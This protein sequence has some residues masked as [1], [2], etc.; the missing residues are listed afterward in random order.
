LEAASE[1]KEH[2]LLEGC[3][4]GLRGEVVEA[5]GGWC[6]AQPA[7]E[8]RRRAD[9]LHERSV[10]LRRHDHDPRPWL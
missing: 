9:L 7:A 2:Q 4:R 10:D 5:A 3:R 8:H 6:R 1:R